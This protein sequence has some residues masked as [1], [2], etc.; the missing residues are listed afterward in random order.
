[1]LKKVFNFA[2]STLVLMSLILILPANALAA[3]TED[4]F[5]SIINSDGYSAGKRYLKDKIDSG[6][7]EAVHLYIKLLIR[8]NTIKKE[9]GYAIAAL[10]KGVQLSDARSAYYLGN[11][12]S[13]GNFINPELSTASRYYEFAAS[14]GHEKAKIKLRDLPDFSQESNNDNG[15]TQDLAEKPEVEKN[16]PDRQTQKPESDKKEENEATV[17]DEDSR[18]RE[19]SQFPAG[20]STQRIEWIAD[21]IDRSQF[22]SFGSGFAISPNGLI[23]T[24]EHVVDGCLRIFVI[25]QGVSKEAKLLRVNSEHDFAVLDINVST[26]SHF[27]I[28]REDPVLGEELISGGFP[29]PEDLGYNLKVTTGIVSSEAPEV[30]W[31]FQ[32]TTPTQKGNSGGPLINRNGQLVGIST[33]VWG[34]KI[35]GLNPQNI[36]FA[37]S[38]QTIVS[39]LENWRLR[40]RTNASSVE[41][42]TKLL[43]DMLKRSATQIICY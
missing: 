33:A 23:L 34:E 9:I 1:M 36:N 28:K 14:L 19:I 39:N 43:A 11:I 22:R 27:Y 16:K 35:G 18:S 13:D 7:I 38:K 24:N 6:D 37:V 3:T 5:F 40:F 42:S 20:Y 29:S 25:Y 8:S 21:P 12:F 10:Q 26:P 41:Y 15:L 31:L 30:G 4:K 17:G 32:H 2:F